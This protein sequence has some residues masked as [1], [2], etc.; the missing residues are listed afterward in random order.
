[1]TTRR[2]TGNGRARATLR[3]TSAIFR[4]ALSLA[5]ITIWASVSIRCFAARSWGS[6]LRIL[7]QPDRRTNTAGTAISDVDRRFIARRSAHWH[8]QSAT[9]VALIHAWAGE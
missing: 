9:A 6:A 2:S 1:M 3:V 7:A 4:P 8:S 5:V